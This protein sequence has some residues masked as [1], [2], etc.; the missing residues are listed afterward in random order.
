[1]TGLIVLKYVV[2]KRKFFVRFLPP[3]LM[4]VV[5]FKHT[6]TFEFYDAFY[7]NVACTDRWTVGGIY[8]NMFHKSTLNKRVR[9]IW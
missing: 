7:K 9:R 4:D 2:K 1:M 3:P 6:I 5:F 8:Q